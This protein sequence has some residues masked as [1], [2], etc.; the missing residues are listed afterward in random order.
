MLCNLGM[1]PFSDSYFANFKNFCKFIN[2]VCFAFHDDFEMFTAGACLI[3]R[4]VF[5]KITKKEKRTGEL[6]CQVVNVLKHDKHQVVWTFQ[7]KS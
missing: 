7:I 5:Q 2:I 6:I 4:N 1:M 3:D